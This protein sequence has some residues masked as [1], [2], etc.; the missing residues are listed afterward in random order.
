MVASSSAS[1][2][3]VEGKVG[4]YEV[5]A[6]LDG[7][8][9]YDSS[10]P[11]FLNLRSC[12]LSK[13]AD[14]DCDDCLSLS[15]GSITSSTSRQG[16]K[17]KVVLEVEAVLDGLGGYNPAPPSFFTSFRNFSLSLTVGAMFF[18]TSRNFFSSSSVMGFHG[19]VAA[20]SR[21]RR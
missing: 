1:R 16:V 9:G 19:V 14:V 20:F 4:A 10:P 6:V 15:V 3:V 13:S 7:L 17:G 21:T 18:T 5:E 11:S 8:G 2:Q 12:T